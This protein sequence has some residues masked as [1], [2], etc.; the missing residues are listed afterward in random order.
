MRITKDYD[1]RRTEILDVAEKLFF[2]KGYAKS[3]VN[4]I[5]NEVG[6]AKGTFYYYFKSKEEVMDAI[7]LRY[8]DMIVKKAEE[9]LAKDLPPKEK[10]LNTFMAMSIGNQIDSRMLDELHKTENSLLHQKILYQMV[11]A[12]S[13]ILAK[14][15]EEGIAKKAWNCKYPLEYMQIFLTAALTLTDEG[16]FDFDADK[17]MKV[18]FALITMLEKILEVPDNQFLELFTQG[19]N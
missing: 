9:V 7:I 10:L 2:T 12:L 11:T 13:P 6:I 16:I 15:I 5:L 1:E 14:V 4:D 8:N 18:V 3:T 19:K 17:Q